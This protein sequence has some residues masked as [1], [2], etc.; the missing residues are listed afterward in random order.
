MS[1]DF[2]GFCERLWQDWLSASLDVSSFVRDTFDMDAAPEPYLSFKA[3]PQ[4]LVALTTNPGA[5]MQHQ[6]RAAVKLGAGPLNDGI[7]YA[8]AAQRLG[9]FYEE[10]LGGSARRRIAGLTAL[11]DLLGCDGVLQ[12]EAC[13]FHSPSLPKKDDLLRALGT[14]ELLSRYVEQVRAVI[15]D[16]PLVAVSAAPSKVSLCPDAVLPRWAE[17]MAELADVVPN[18]ASFVPLVT[19]G[20]KTTCGAFVVRSGNVSKALVLMMGS[21]QLPGKTALGILADALG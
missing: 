4:P 7:S 17:W 3:G 12:V 16:K 5:T 18:R 20:S 19:K 6:R 11:S 2:G 14:D 13:P 9:K 21:N 15:R 1:D 10:Q 8:T